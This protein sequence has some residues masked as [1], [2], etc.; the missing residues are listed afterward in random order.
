MIVFL[1]LP[2]HFTLSNVCGV[3]MKTGFEEY[4]HLTDEQIKTAWEKGL[5]VFDTNVLLGLYRI[6]ESARTDLLKAF[7]IIKDR[8]WIPHQ[9]ALEY[10]RR[11]SFAAFKVEQE[12]AELCKKTKDLLGSLKGSFNHR[13]S[14]VASALKILDDSTTKALD[15]IDILAKSV[16]HKPTSDQVLIRLATLIDDAKI[17][18]AY[19]SLELE[20]KHTEA[21][22][23]YHKNIPPG[24]LDARGKKPKPKPRCYS[25]YVL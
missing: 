11:R 6:T 24:Y 3:T 17:G 13:N 12:L 2:D 25:D 22:E 16:H 4:L 9:V 23:R 7:D 19:S 8:I 14:I 18:P 1:H 15:N 21:E 5:F 10:H 20:K